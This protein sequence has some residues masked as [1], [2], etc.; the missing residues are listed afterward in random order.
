MSTKT[1]APD[2][3]ISIDILS[4]YIHL[5]YDDY[6]RLGKWMNNVGIVGDPP[7][8]EGFCKGF[9]FKKRDTQGKYWLGIYLPAGASI[10]TISHECTHA[11]TFILDITNVYFDVKEDEI[12]AYL[13]GYILEKVWEFVEK[14]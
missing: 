14:K 13:Q 1:L 9:A 7:L 11:A 8:M 12:L 5:F 4:C 6:E 10:N 2:L 3:V